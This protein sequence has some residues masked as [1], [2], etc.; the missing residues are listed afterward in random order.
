MALPISATPTYTLEI[1]SN[2]KVVKYRPFLIKEEKSLLLAQQSEDA[3]V[4]VDTLK[5]VISSCVKDEIDVDSLATFDIEYIFCQLRGKSVGEDAELFFY[6]DT[7]DD[8][9][10]KAKVVIDLSEVKVDKPEGHTNKIE[11]FDDVGVMMK[12]PTGESIKKFDNVGEAELDQIFDVVSDCIDYVYT[13]DEIF[14]A[15]D[16]TK[17]ELYDFLDNLT[18]EQFA[19]I[20]KFYDT[21]PKIRYYVDYRCPVCGKEH[22]KVLEGLNSFF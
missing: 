16:Q 21:M 20:Q 17:Q 15:K 2:G 11:L 5:S 6:C 3:K 8:E 7:C 18:T 13:N 19:K 9:K 14:Y 22:H 12:Y 4:M 10:A 1:P